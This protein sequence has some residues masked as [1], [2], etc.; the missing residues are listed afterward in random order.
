MIERVLDP[1][2]E[3]CFCC[4]IDQADGTVV[5]QQQ[6]GRDIADGRTVRILGAAHREQELML[7]RS[8]PH[9][10]GLFFTPM[11]EASELGAEQ[12]EPPIVGVREVIRR[13]RI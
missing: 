10:L 6:R 12:Q 8:D 2:D 9:A 13:H 11:E 3:T 7:G 5:A 1:A 4:S